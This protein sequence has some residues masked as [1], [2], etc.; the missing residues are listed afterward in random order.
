MNAISYFFIKLRMQK[1]DT[2]KHN[3]KTILISL[4]INKS[5]KTEKNLV[6]I[7]YN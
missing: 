4:A 6:K 5:V 1:C 7:T 3:N 2:V